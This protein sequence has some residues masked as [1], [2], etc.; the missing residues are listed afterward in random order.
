ML[1][2]V[3]AKPINAFDGITEYIEA[4]GVCALSVHY[5]I[6]GYSD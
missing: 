3:C 6:R 2:D 1:I 4:S 5:S